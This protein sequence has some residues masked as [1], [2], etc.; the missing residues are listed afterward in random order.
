MKFLVTNDD[1]I[2]AE[3]L[4]QL[5][6]SLATLGD[7]T[8]V[9]PDSERS[10]TGHAITMHFP[11]R[12]REVKL[13]GPKVQAYAVD[14]TPADCV[15]LGIDELLDER[16]DF[17]FTGINRGA[18]LGT[19]VL[20]SGT[21]SAAI[22]GCIMGVRSAAFSLLFG[23]GNEMDYT[24]A[25]K[26]A[27][28]VAKIISQIDFTPDTLINVNIPNA[29]ESQIQGMKVTRLGR[30]RYSKSYEKR[31]DPR[32]RTYYWLSGKLIEEKTD[33]DIDIDATNQK[34]VSITPL[35]FDLTS[36]KMMDTF[37]S[38]GFEKDFLDK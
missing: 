5:A 1:G 10:A 19:D 27:I 4:I 30:I 21:V 20:Y 12:V 23:D 37:R 35:H 18:N 13:P 38:W 17:V 31:E 32:G 2:H 9:A 3:G 6:A 24:F 33:S 7:V 26:I 14:G 25:G 34:Y 11:L 36:Y 28:K 22:E 15:K 8:V 29:P 16:P